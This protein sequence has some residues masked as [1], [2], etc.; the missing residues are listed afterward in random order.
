VGRGRAEGMGDHGEATD[1]L[2]SPPALLASGAGA[3]AGG[4]MPIV[5]KAQ[6]AEGIPVEPIVPRGWIGL[7][8]FISASAQWVELLAI[9]EGSGHA[10]IGSGA[11]LLRPDAFLA[12]C[13]PAIQTNRAGGGAWLDAIGAARAAT[14]D[15]TE[16]SAASDVASLRPCP[17]AQSSSVF[18]WV[19][20]AACAEGIAGLVEASAGVLPSSSAAAC[21]LV[22]AVAWMAAALVACPVPAA[23]L[24]GQCAT[25][26]RLPQGTTIGAVRLP[27]ASLVLQAS[28]ISESGTVRGGLSGDS[29]VS[30]AAAEG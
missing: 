1:R 6:V 14:G 12:G 17:Q 13:V 26:L 19:A 18:G 27:A 24:G 23:S 15:V 11:S 2:G 3:A 25:A 22:D 7:S 30:S 4:D 28:Q 20:A 8:T 9:A 21:V 16:L 29:A 10:G 5:H